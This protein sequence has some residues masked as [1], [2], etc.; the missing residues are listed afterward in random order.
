MNDTSKRKLI[1]YMGT[2]NK[3]SRHPLDDE[4]FVDFIKTSHSAG[5]DIVD[6]SKELD[7]LLEKN[8]F[9]DYRINNLVCAY[10]FGM[11]VLGNKI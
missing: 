7:E 6:T 4:K 5:D 8:H 2:A 1:L 10:E 9:A 3:S 11:M